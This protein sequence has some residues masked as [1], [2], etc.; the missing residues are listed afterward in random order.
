MSEY[1]P[2]SAPPAFDDPA[3]EIAAQRVYG[4][5]GRLAYFGLSILIGIVSN[6]VTSVVLS[7]VTPDQTPALIAVVVVAVLNLTASVTVIV[8]RLKNLGMNGFW[9]L[10]L[11]VPILNLVIAV[12]LIAAPEG[13]AD[14]K[15][16]DTPGKWIVGIFIGLFVLALVIV[17]I[18]VSR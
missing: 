7:L 9:V 14:H 10:G 1:N 12:R 8:L 4:G 3:S 11:I 15:T 13:Y 17:A 16:L 5:I 2:F 6:V 18:A